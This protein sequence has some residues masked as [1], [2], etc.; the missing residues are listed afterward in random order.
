M[1]TPVVIHGEATFG[2]AGGE[3][4][5]WVGESGS[6]TFDAIADAYYIVFGDIATYSGDIILTVLGSTDQ[7][8][9]FANSS[10]SVTLT[11]PIEEMLM[12]HK[13]AGTITI[14]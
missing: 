9:L 5:W 3:G 1:P 7:R 2:A 10:G 6:I 11:A 13:L 8:R 4:P 14:T 12:L